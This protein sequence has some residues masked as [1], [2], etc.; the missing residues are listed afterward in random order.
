MLMSVNGS[1]VLKIVHQPDIIHSV[2]I[3]I[4]CLVVA[5][6]D[7]TR[8]IRQL[9]LRPLDLLF[10][11][12]RSKRSA[13]VQPRLNHFVYVATIFGDVGLHLTTAIVLLRLTHAANEVQILAS[14][15]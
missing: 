3:T 11:Q 12:Q 1:I 7:M 6:N 8:V 9:L 15:G 14:S 4:W 2:R 13:F 10:F 5:V